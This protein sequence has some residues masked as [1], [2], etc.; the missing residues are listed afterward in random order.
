MDILTFYEYSNDLIYYNH[1]RKT[2]QS[3]SDYWA[4]SHDAYEII[5]YKKGSI[6]YTI[7]G[8]E[9]RLAQHDLVFTRPFDIHYIDTFENDTYE[10]Y[11][12]LFDKSILPDSISNKITRDINVLSFNNNQNVINLFKKMDFYCENVH[13]EELGIVLKNLIQEVCVNIIIEAKNSAVHIHTISNP[14]VVDAINYIEEHLTT[15]TGIQ[16]ICDHLFITKSHLQHLFTEH[17]K[18]SPKKY[19]ITKRLALAQAEMLSGGKPT[20]ICIKCGFGDYSAFYRAY[21]NY[22][23]CSPSGKISSERVTLSHDNTPRISF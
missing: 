8:Q 14:I 21:K 1:A 4:H 15:L 18:I 10:R 19:I 12:I 22:F 9:Y 2:K 16:E 23:H 3:R 7:N 5:F 6:I 11:N 20:E 17:L 13:G